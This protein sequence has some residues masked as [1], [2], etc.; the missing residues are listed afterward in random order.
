[1]SFLVVSFIPP[2]YAEDEQEVKTKNNKEHA[3]SL[4]DTE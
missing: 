1:M 4:T 2:Y 3:G